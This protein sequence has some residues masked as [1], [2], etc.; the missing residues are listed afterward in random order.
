M[1]LEQSIL[2]AVDLTKRLEMALN[3]GEL[4]LCQDLMEIRGEA[5]MVFE[6]THRGSSSKEVGQCGALLEE[7]K[8]ADAEL[9]KKYQASLKTVAEEFR[10]GLKSGA[11]SAGGTYSSQTIPACIDRKA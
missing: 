1:N 4:E 8:A 3:V 9:Q 11:G 2:S 5:M 10:Q 6:A 7:L